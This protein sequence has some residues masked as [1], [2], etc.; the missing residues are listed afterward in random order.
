MLYRDDQPGIQQIKFLDSGERVLAISC[1]NINRKAEEAGEGS[2]PL[3]AI[4]KVKQK[5]FDF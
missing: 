3:V 2:D 4:V 1:A 5:S